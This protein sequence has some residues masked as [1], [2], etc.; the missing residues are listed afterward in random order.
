MT[1]AGVDFDIHE[2]LVKGNVYSFIGKLKD[3]QAIYLEGIKFNVTWTG[4]GNDE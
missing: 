2:E 3:D 1:Y 4:E